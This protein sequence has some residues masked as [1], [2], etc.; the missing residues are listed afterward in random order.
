MHKVSYCYDEYHAATE[1]R[2]QMQAEVWKTIV[3]AVKRLFTQRSST[4]IFFKSHA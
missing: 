3:T 4:G 1:L 2:A